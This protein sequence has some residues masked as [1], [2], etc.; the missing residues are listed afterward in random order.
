LR[1]THLS[2]ILEGH[3]NATIADKQ[4]PLTLHRSLCDL[5]FFSFPIDIGDLG[6]K[7]MSN[8]TARRQPHFLAYYLI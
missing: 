6:R 7:S 2:A 4:H 1:C 8:I 3:Y 5:A